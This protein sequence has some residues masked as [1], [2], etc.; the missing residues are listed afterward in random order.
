MP[1]LLVLGDGHF[2]RLDELMHEKRK[3]DK[4]VARTIACGGVMEL[5]HS[6]LGDRTIQHGLNEGLGV[7]RLPSWW[8]LN[9]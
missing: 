9:S 4:C 5:K 2:N 1:Q 8:I 3:V 7:P 6:G